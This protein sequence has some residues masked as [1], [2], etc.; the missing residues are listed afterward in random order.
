MALSKIQKA[1]EIMRHLVT[2]DGDAGHGY[3]QIYRWGD[4]TTEVIT[5]SD[6]TK[7]TVPNGDFDCS[8]AIIT[9][10]KLAG[11]NT[12]N[13][14]YT[15][16]MSNLLCATGAFVRKPVSFIAS[17]GDAY[18]HDQ[19]HVAMCLSQVP[20][21]LME[22]SINEKGGIAGG[23]KGDQT[24]RES[25]IN[26]Y[27]NYPWTCILRYV[28]AEQTPT[29]VPIP[30]Q[31]PQ[32]TPPTNYG[33]GVEYEVHTRKHGW[34]GPVSEASDNLATGYAGWQSEPIDG[35]RARRKDGKPLTITTLMSGETKF[36]NT[37]T[38]TNSLF[39]KNKEGDGY[40]GDINSGRH[41]VGL[42]VTGCDLRVAVAG[43]PYFG[44]L[45]NGK[46]PEGDDFA[47]DDVGKN[48][49]IVAVQMKV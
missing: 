24:G 5:L 44:W 16:N 41:I 34:L 47:G 30:S 9:A 20:D 35:I 27:Y 19:Y 46:T 23:K 32:P 45:E 49:P 1:V 21:R 48:R 15:G 43:Q 14:S 7:V 2:H 13:A 25:A 8:S 39:G 29:P 12:N 11:I 10:Y 17:P 37:T 6:G 3:D 36:L 40:A 28:G 26:N 4:G 42:K 31:P 33:S 22:F 38:F 18:L